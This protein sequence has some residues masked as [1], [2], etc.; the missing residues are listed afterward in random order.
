MTKY[1]NMTTGPLDVPG[2][3]FIASKGEV[4]LDAKEAKQPII[5]Q[6]IR[7]GMLDDGKPKKDAK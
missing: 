6:W 5:A 7:L 2:K 3:G 4:D 1:K